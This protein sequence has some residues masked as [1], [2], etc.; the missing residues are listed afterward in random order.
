MEANSEG[1]NVAAFPCSFGTCEDVSQSKSSASDV[2]AFAYGPGS[3][4]SIDT[5]QAYS[6]RTQFFADMDA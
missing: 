2:D 3:S 6:V 4:Y 1:F 5:D